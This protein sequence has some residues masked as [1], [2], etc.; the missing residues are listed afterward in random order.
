MFYVLLHLICISRC[1]SACKFDSV[2]VSPRA[3]SEGWDGQGGLD[4]P[5]IITQN[6]GIF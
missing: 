6:M 5:E 2:L 1:V 3:D 4:T